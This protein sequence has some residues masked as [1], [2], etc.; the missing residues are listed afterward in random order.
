MSKTKFSRFVAFL[1]RGSVGA[2]R[3]LGPL[4]YPLAS[5]SRVRRSGRGPEIDLELRQ[6][7][8]F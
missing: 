8:R 4:K 7:L 3:D 2:T 1:K 5:I 6:R